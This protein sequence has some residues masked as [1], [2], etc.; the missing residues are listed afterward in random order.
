MSL[1]LRIDKEEDNYWTLDF[2]YSTS[3]F[4][5]TYSVYEPYCLSLEE[6]NDLANGTP[7]CQLNLYQG[8]GEGT[9]SVKGNSIVFVSHPSGAG[10]DT[11]SEV[12]IPLD[13]VTKPLKEKLIEASKLGL[14]F[15]DPNHR[16]VDHVKMF[17]YECQ[18]YRD[19]QEMQEKSCTLCGGRKCKKLH[20]G[21]NLF[22]CKSCNK[23]GLCVDCHSFNKCCS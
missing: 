1:K 3:Q 17:C 18:I 21:D 9:I 20:G 23:S 22:D 11:Y 19:R 10:G 2:N 16:H 15:A 13:I 14:R 5:F 12:I 8:N 7:D 4:N 6:W